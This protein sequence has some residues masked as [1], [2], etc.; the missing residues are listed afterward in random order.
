MLIK[1]ESDSQGKGFTH[2]WYISFDLGSIWP[3]V[4]K[5]VPHTTF[6]VPY[7]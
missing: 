3:V 7:T 2:Y 5:L 6:F 4:N 1:H